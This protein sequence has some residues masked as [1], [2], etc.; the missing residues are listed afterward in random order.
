MKIWCC[1][2]K[3]GKI[4]DKNIR[5]L[6]FKNITTKKTGQLFAHNKNY[7]KYEMYK[8]CLGAL[9]LSLSASFIFGEIHFFLSV[10]GARKS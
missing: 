1:I 8:T 7:P 6:L 5:E 3:E 10:F 4:R 2:I 9:A